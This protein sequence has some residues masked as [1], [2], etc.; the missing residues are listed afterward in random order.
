MFTYAVGMLVTFALVYGVMHSLFPR[1]WSFWKCTLFAAVWPGTWM[2]LFTRWI[3][4]L[5][6]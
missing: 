3:L 5:T 1:S 2:Y 4:G 6:C